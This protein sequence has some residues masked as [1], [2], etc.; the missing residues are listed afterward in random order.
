MRTMR[1]SGSVGP[2]GMATLAKVFVVGTP[3]EGVCGP[4]AE[5]VVMSVVAAEIVVGG[6]S[7]RTGGVA[8]RILPSAS[9][10]L[11]DDAS[12]GVPVPEGCGEDTDDACLA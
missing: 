6:V 11:D 8:E 4:E 3:D 10:V 7:D 9:E 1:Y 2:V 5:P 12:V